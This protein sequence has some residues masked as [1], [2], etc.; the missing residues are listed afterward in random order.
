MLPGLRANELAFT[1][2]EPAERARFFRPKMQLFG[3]TGEDLAKAARRR[4]LLLWLVACALVLGG[5][6]G[7]FAYKPWRLRSLQRA[8]QEA[9]KNGDY[10]AATFNARRALQIDADFIPACVVM[11]E[12]GE[13]NRVPDAVM[14]REKVLHLKGESADTL[15]GLASTALS[16]GKTFTARSALERVPAKDRER[17]D[18]LVLSG[19]LALEARDYRPSIPFYE[20]AIRLNPRKAEYQLAL[21]RAKC[22]SEDSSIHDEGRGL[23][24]ELGAHKTLGATAM[25]A[26]IADCEAHEE[27]PAALRYTQELL[28]QPSHKFSDELLLLRLM[29]KTKDERFAATLADAQRKAQADPKHAGG[30][31]LWMSMDGLAKDGLEWVLKRTPKLGQSPELRPAMAGC[32]LTLV[33]WTALLA[34][35]QKGEWDAVEYVRHAYRSRAFHEQAAWPLARTEWELAITTANGQIDALAWLSQLATEWKWNDETAESLWALLDK[36]PGTKWAVETLQKSYLQQRD[37]L[38]LRQLALHLVKTDPADEN[39]QNDLALASILLNI[40]PDRAM[41]IAR[42]LYTKHPDNVAF[43]STYAFALHS[44]GRTA[45]GL[46]ILEKLPPERLEDPAIAAYYGIML[47]ANFSAK[48]AS[49]FLEIGRKGSLLP[50]EK[51]LVAQA[52]QAIAAGKE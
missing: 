32:Y 47:A 26:V 14:W 13:H 45:E 10:V 7:S 1:R 21:G 50:E 16:F 31:L 6:V 15:L 49:R 17:E 39:A 8:S 52:E 36:A 5:T 9:V 18:F 3:T 22:A 43:N 25:R 38:G 2:V 27:Y 40:E 4:M 29:H 51:Q 30:L 41:K 23:L 12:V 48:K 11:A 35:T 28:T 46:E 20:A 37:T 44:T 19:A 34:I 42:D 24:L 33:D